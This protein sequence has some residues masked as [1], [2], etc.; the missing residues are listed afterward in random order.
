MTVTCKYVYLLPHVYIVLWTIILIRAYR[1]LSPTFSFVGTG[2]LYSSAK[3]VLCWNVP[4]LET[5]LQM[6]CIQFIKEVVY[7]TQGLIFHQLI[8]SS[9]L[10]LWLLCEHLIPNINTTVSEKTWTIIIAR[11]AGKSLWMRIRIHRF[12][13][14]ICHSHCIHLDRLLKFSYLSVSVMVL[15]YHGNYVMKI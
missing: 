1:G 6:Y 14:Q 12:W 13:A 10:T 2:D 8:C 9:Y 4:I 15:F 11:C 3:S 5:K 7:G